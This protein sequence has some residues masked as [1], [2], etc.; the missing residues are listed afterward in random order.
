MTES[1][2]ALAC[3]IEGG[4][5]AREIAAFYEHWKDNRLVIDKWFAVQVAHA[6]PDA[7]AQIA[8]RLSQH[9]DFEWKNPNRF[10]SLMGALAANHAGFHHV[11]GAAYRFYAD[12][13]LQLDAVN[14]Q[15]TAR[16][17][18]AFETWTRYDG[19]RKVLIRAEL[20]RIAA[21]PD[22]SRDT[23]EMVTRILAAD[24]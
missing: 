17:S 2:G 16:M 12:W 20:E 24:A 14:P 9:P 8:E 5:G 22:L 23:F 6:K 11:S 18:T 7:A 4:R 21:T 15:T 1:H 13:L 10:R 3:L 19:N